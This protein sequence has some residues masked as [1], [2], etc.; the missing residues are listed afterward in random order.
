MKSRLATTALVV[1]ATVFAHVNNASAQQATG[2][3]GNEAVRIV[4]GKRVV[5]APPIYGIHSKKPSDF[6]PPTH[7][8]NRGGE[9][10]MIEGP[11]GLK[12]CSASVFMDS[13]CIPS[14]IGT[15]KRYRVWIVKLKG[16]WQ[17]C[18]SRVAPMVCKPLRPT[19]KI[20]DAMLPPSNTGME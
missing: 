5:E 3:P 15:V 18:N 14:D 9:V 7:V 11:D 17:R 19:G 4:G 10:M 13:A 12:A 16:E 1:A 2:F 8:G 20:A 6:S